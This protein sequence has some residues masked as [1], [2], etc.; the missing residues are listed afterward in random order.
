MTLIINEAAET[1]IAGMQTLA[2]EY[3]RQA[4]AAD[5]DEAYIS[6]FLNRVYS[7]ASL[8][9]A[10]QS[11]G[12][13]FLVARDD[14]GIVGLCNFGSPLLDDCR[15]RKEIFR[16]F[17]HPQRCRQGTGGKLIAET[18]KR[19]GQTGIVNECI[20]YVETA[21]TIRQ[22]FYQK[23]KFRHQPA[24]DTDGNWCLVRNI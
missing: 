12:A 2:E 7:E 10:I 15:E 19:L 16:L 21:D 22:N 13:T 3:F 24:R 6:R 17:V 23:Y 11:D 1:D 9:R 14:D 4:F 5:H 8:K 18:V 20:V